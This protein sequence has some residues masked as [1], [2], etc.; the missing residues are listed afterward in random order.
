[1]WNKKPD[2]NWI[3]NKEYELTILSQYFIM[4]H[5]EILVTAESLSEWLK[6]IKDF[7]ERKKPLRGDADAVL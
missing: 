7:K 5:N 3:K 1:M 4:Y 2:L 6:D